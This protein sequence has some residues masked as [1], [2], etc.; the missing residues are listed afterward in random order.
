[1]ATLPP[2]YS[3][4]DFLESYGLKIWDAEDVR[5][6]MTILEYMVASEQCWQDTKDSLVNIRGCL[7]N[8]I[9]S[10]L[11]DI[12]NHKIPLSDTSRWIQQLECLYLESVADTASNSMKSKRIRR[13]LL[14]P[15]TN[16]KY[17]A[18]S[19]TWCVSEGEMAKSGGYR[20]EKRDDMG[21]L[22]TKIRN[23]VLQRAIKFAEY[24]GCKYFWIDKECIN[25]ED[26]IQ[27]EL[28]IQSMDLVY[29][30]SDSPVAL[31]PVC[32]NDA[33]CLTIL[34]EL[35]R[36]KFVTNEIRPKLRAGMRARSR[37]AL[38]VLETIT[39][40]RWWTRAWTFQEDYRAATKMT[41]L[42]CHTQD[43]E[44]SKL[45]ATE[46]FGTLEGE[47][48]VNS[49]TFRTEATRFCL[50]YKIEQSSRTRKEDELCDVIL[51]RAGKYTVLLEHYSAEAGDIVCRPM[52]PLVLADLSARGLEEPFD[53]LAIA[54]NVCNYSVRLNTKVLSSGGYSLSMALLALYLLNGEIM[55]GSDW[56]SHQDPDLSLAE[57]VLQF[58]CSRSLRSLS[59]PVAQKLTFAKNCRFVNVKLTAEGVQTKGH[60]WKL[61]KNV[62]V[63]SRFQPVEE[64]D[65]QHGLTNVER[66]WLHWLAADLN[67]G[68][69]GRQ[70]RHLAE[71]LLDYLAEDAAVS[72]GNAAKDFK[73]CMAREIIGAMQS[74]RPITMVSNMD[75]Q[76][77]E[78]PSSYSGLVVGDDHRD[79]RYIFTSWG[80]AGTFGNTSRHVCLAV[81]MHGCTKNGLA[82]LTTIKWMN[83]LIFFRGIQSQPV[84]FPWPTCFTN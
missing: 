72:R 76:R 47:L 15:R 20:I 40:T 44:A 54:S 84:V 53:I 77:P 18:V 7:Q 28:A 30:S 67:S 3:W 17:V 19:Y 46:L 9:S 65:P 5:E 29:H 66:L 78:R 21:F 26:L 59:P 48:C 42:L 56:M 32:I 34:V 27:K 41:L 50:A 61:G 35:L 31:L 12:Q 13:C 51:Q 36:G 43:L 79:G 74:G 71:Q 64:D 11:I 4:Q 2:N 60:V 39:A 68:K 70:Y 22:P 80:R 23:V 25:Q 58:L 10:T 49:V 83:G 37:D 14:D 55:V 8:S 38:K 69:L 81:D 75:P 45:A 52:S 6:G 24:R 33:E 63:S 1:M 62:V 73:D 16:N 82:K 57:T